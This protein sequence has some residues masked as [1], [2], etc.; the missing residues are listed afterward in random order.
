MFSRDIDVSFDEFLQFIALREVASSR[1][2]NSVPYLKHHILAL[3]SKYIS[4]IDLDTSFLEELFSGNSTIIDPTELY[5]SVSN[6]L[7]GEKTEE[8]NEAIE[9][10]EFT[11][12]LIEAWIDYIATTS[13][14]P[15]LNSVMKIREILNRRRVTNGPQYQALLTLLGIELKHPLIQKAYTF[16]EQTTAKRGAFY[17]DSLWNH[18]DF[19]PTKETIDKKGSLGAKKSDKG[20][21]ASKTD[22]DASFEDLVKGF[23]E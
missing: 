7:A 9:H 23:E 20:N 5:K 14:L 22:W 2:Y 4:T 11:L 21:K 8:Q 16:W 15:H 18:P 19:L 10:L 17:R 12:S 13:A 6:E 1:L 3:V